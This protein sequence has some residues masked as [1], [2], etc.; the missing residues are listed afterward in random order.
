MMLSWLHGRCMSRTRQTL[1][2]ADLVLLHEALAYTRKRS[3]L[4]AETVRLQ[5]VQDQVEALLLGGGASGS[6][7]LS[8]PEQEVLAREIPRYCEAL[9]QRGGSEKGTHDAARLRA[10]LELLVPGS[11]GSWWRRLLRR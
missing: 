5:G 9:T 7:R 3:F 1:T 11:G 8:P 2:R 10:L 6:L 4:P